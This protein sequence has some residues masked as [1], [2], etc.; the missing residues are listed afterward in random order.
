[1]YS[2]DIDLRT[3]CTRDDAISIILGLGHWRLLP[4]GEDA[5]DEEI[6]NTEFITFCLAEYLHEELDLLQSKYD[7]ARWENLSE[8]DIAE[9][10]AALD[11]FK[12]VIT[13]AKEYSSCFDDEIAKG[14]S[15]AIRIHPSSGLGSNTL[16]TIRSVEQWARNNQY[17]VFAQDSLIENN[18]EHQESPPADNKTEVITTKQPRMPAQEN[19]ILEA[20]KGLGHDPKNLQTNSSGNNGVKHEVRIALEKNE[21]FSGS[22]TFDKAWER[23]R[24]RK[25]IVDKE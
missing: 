5:T 17:G 12:E 15:S 8:A 6:E 16:Y 23:L 7:F 25:K 11:K 1:M 20:I 3:C 22:R 2:C 10:L 24:N 18:P 21:L 14:E 4:P 13:K 9:K 19:A